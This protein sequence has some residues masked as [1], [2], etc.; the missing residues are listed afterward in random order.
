M[1]VAAAVTEF[2]VAMQVSH[3]AG[4]ILRFRQTIRGEAA[5]LL[6]SADQL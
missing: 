1:A 6:F 2:I 5:V 3:N 4:M